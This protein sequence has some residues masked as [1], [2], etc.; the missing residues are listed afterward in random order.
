MFRRT[1]K[2]VNAPQSTA[3]EPDLRARRFMA[4]AIT[5]SQLANITN[6][7][8]LVAVA[9]V[10]AL[11]LAL[12]LSFREPP[13]SSWW[14]MGLMALTVGAGVMVF[15]QYGRIVGRDPGVALLF[16]FGP[17]KLIEARSSRDFMVVW[18]LGLMLFVA[19]FFD[20]L[21]LVAALSVPPVIIVYV[22]ALRL[23]D[24]PSSGSTRRGA[25]VELWSEV[26]SAATHVLLGVP[27]AAVMFVLFP[28]AAAPLWGMNDPS[29][30]KSGL[31]EEM[32]PGKISDLILSKETAFR[33]EFEKRVPSAANL[34][35]RGPVLREF[36]GGTWRGGMGSNGFSRGEF[37]AFSPEEHEREAINYTVTVDKQE[38]RW[39]PMLELPLAYP[40]GPGVE[41][42]L[43]LTDAQQIGVRGV[44]NGALQYRAQAL[45]R[46]TYSAPQPT[47]TSVDVQTGPREWNPRTRA[48]AANLASRFPEPRSRIVA[49]LKTFNAE[50]F[51]YTLKP[52]LYGADKDITAIDEFLFDG[53]RGFCEHYAGST[54]FILRA[55]GI[56]ARVVTG[57]Q[58]GEFH[59]S[60][61]MIVR[62]SDAHA[63]V[64]AWFDGSWTRID[65]TAAVAPNR[66]ER[67][68]EFSLP[69]AERMFI[70]TQG[71]RGLQGI[72][73]LWEEANFSYTKWVI[74]F[75]RDRQQALLKRM[76]LE[77]INPLTALGWM[78]LAITASG[79][80]MAL[81]WWLF[82][83]R[84]AR[85]ADPWLRTW[86][87]LRKRL[88]S[89]GLPINTHDTVSTAMA[90]AAAK[91][92]TH[93]PAFSD[94]A[95]AYNR[96]RF[97][98]TPD[99]RMSTPKTMAGLPSYWQ[100]RAGR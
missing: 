73:N 92:P 11:L 14:R 93:A 25:V 52:P 46:G 36:D 1:P 100:L 87:T 49:L 80:L 53:R 58:G 38:S 42:T 21:G 35:W 30:S 91:W 37:I 50:Q 83:Q 66:I 60:G 9:G 71:W 39:L 65:P 70:N 81:V 62:Q 17:L 44:P 40:S 33:V 5:L 10:T 29:S 54:A 59:P 95:N 82:H 74:G 94:F 96:S 7:K 23:L 76:G 67:G 86:K 98:P 16:I 57:Y 27:L 22:A 84:E 15:T 26:K 28:R 69:D 34:Y 51:Y 97:A 41:R 64:E 13:R 78:L 55:S 77:G 8:P 24:A 75:D 31:S 32:R 99:Q 4:F 18:G 90:R 63:W 85:R 61:Y 89:A 3:I 79:G 12:A 2:A 68:L 43:Y 20:N 45:V 6:I 88:Q 47:E 56:P 72:K 19:S 48:F